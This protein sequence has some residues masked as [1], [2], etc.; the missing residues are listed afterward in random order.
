LKPLRSGLDTVDL[1]DLTDAARSGPSSEVRIVASADGCAIPRFDRVATE[2]PL[3]IRVRAAHETRR[4]AITMRTL[5]N[6]SE[7]A[8]GFLFCEGVIGGY[9]AL[10]GI[11]YCI[12]PAIGA[13]Q[14]YNI[15]N[16]TLAADELPAFTCSSATSRRRARA[17]SAVSPVWKRCL[18]GIEAI[19]TALR[20]GA[21]TITKPPGTVARSPRDLR[22]DR[23][24]TRR[25][26]LRSG[27][28]PRRAARGRRQA[29]RARQIDRLGT[30]GAAP[31]ACRTHRHG[32]RT[33]ELR[34]RSEGAC[35]PGFRCSAPFPHRAAL[36]SIWR[37]R[38]T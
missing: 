2:E 12:D 33:C 35:R 22:E 1:R 26:T 36:P 13:E 15:V 27:G 29:Q 17:A 32:Q 6:D 34:T 7:L 37:A 18:R 30:F 16:V 28:G 4:V 31:A 25:R 3:E 9:D 21:G 38:S 11:S 23:R 19:E 24:P 10:N 8:A 20:V 5:G 14:R